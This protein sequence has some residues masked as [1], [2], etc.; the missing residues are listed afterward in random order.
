V[1]IETKCRMYIVSHRPGVKHPIRFYVASII[2]PRATH[3]SPPCVE[4]SM[5]VG[6]WLQGGV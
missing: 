6:I 4:D 1:I 2:K 5:S 3:R